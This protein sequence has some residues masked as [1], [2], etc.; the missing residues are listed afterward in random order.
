MT[1]TPAQ[2]HE[3]AIVLENDSLFCAKYKRVASS[4]STAG[5]RR[6]EIRPFVQYHSGF[7]KMPFPFSRAVT[8]NDVEQL[9]RYFDDTFNASDTSGDNPYAGLETIEFWLDEVRN[10]DLT[11]KGALNPRLIP[12]VEKIMKIPGFARIQEQGTV[13]DLALSKISQLARHFGYSADD[14]DRQAVKRELVKRASLPVHVPGCPIPIPAPE[15]LAEWQA[16]QPKEPTM[17]KPIEITTKTLVNG[18]DVTTMTDSQVYDLIAAEET[19]I[20]EL[21]KI[22]AKPKKLTAEIQKRK[23]GILALVAHL[24]KAA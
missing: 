17:S 2:L 20:K 7:G 11:V 21:E 19:K 4:S 8:T 15:Y 1:C 16:S 3:M 12:L 9:R 13:A 10:P 18:V 22:E 14:A 6:T 24:D 23:D 5:A